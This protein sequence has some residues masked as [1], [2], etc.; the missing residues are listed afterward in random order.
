[1]FRATYRLSNGETVTVPDVDHVPDLNMVALIPD[2]S[3][4]YGQVISVQKSDAIICKNCKSDLN[5]WFVSSE[6][7][8]DVPDG[9][10]RMSEVSPIAFISCVECGETLRVVDSNA[11]ETLLNSP[12]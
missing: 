11:I 8:K 6:G 12:R 7:P 1:M 3:G 5:M 2:K 10:I 9:R 4:R